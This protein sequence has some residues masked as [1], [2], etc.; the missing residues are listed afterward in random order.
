MIAL[1]WVII[2]LTVLFFVAVGITWFALE[3]SDVVQLVTTKHDGPGLRTTRAWFIGD[4]QQ[5][6]Q[7]LLEAGTPQN[8]WV[9]DIDK[10]PRLR[11]VHN[12]QSTAYCTSKQSDAQ[13]HQR[14]RTLMRSKYGWR[15]W[16]VDALFDVSRSAL[17][18]LK[19]CQ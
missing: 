18:V 4:T 17:V 3:R 16:W 10:I 9:L 15:D 14:I 19:P 6:E 1:K 11:L 8:P 2:S 12:E 13:S 7:V 5:S